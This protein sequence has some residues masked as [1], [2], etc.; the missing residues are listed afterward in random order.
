M[1]GKRDRK[2]RDQ[3]P[4]TNTFIYDWRYIILMANMDINTDLLDCRL[5]E[6]IRENNP[7]PYHAGYIH[8]IIASYWML[9]LVDFRVGL[10]L[11]AV[12]LAR[13]EY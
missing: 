5:M 7:H 3:N 4:L 1:G 8:G 11:S 13:G 12:S 10:N 9:N 6:S 2:D